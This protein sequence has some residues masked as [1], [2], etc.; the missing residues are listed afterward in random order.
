MLLP[1]QNKEFAR[2]YYNTLPADDI[3]HQYYQKGL[4]YQTP[5]KFL[6]VLGAYFNIHHKIDALSK[7][8][9]YHRTIQA[10]KLEYEE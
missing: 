9:P 2:Q 5:T 4:K 1:T 3:N 6:D 10:T 8:Y 7:F